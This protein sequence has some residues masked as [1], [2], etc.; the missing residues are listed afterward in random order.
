MTMATDTEP[1]HL[2]MARDFMRRKGQ[3][4]E[5][6]LVEQEGPELWY[7]YYELPQ[8]RL[9][10]EVFYDKKKDDWEVAVTAFPVAL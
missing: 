5:P 10:L 7:C 9:E 6:V 2:V 1:A 4:L 8:G 3:H